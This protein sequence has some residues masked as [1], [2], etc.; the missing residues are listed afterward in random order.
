MGSQFN[1]SANPEF[2]S[3]PKT[4]WMFWAQGEQNMPT[5]VKQCVSSWRQHNP[6]WVLTIVTLDNMQNYVDMSPITERDNYSFQWLAD[7]LR[8]KLIAKS[9]GVWAD[10]TAFCAKPLDS[11]LPNY[12]EG[13]FFA[14][15]AKQ[16]DRLIQNW[17]LASIPDGDIINAWLNESEHYWVSNNF[18]P[19]N[20]WRRQ[21]YRK[22]MSFRKRGSL[23]NNIWFSPFITKTIKLQ[24]YPVVMFLF[25]KALESRPGL[26][27]LWQSK[28]KLTDEQPHKLQNDFRMNQVLSEESK[29][30][31]DKSPS[32]LHK[33][34][35]RQCPESLKQD[36][37]LNYLLT[38][39]YSAKDQ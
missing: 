2:D 13:G 21:V 39:T 1:N 20:Y 10:A 33:L 31:I 35:W 11:W 7:I 9:G 25:E 34:N 15:S 14:F 36:S 28:P 8:M 6:N 19:E 26:K 29:S 4:I 23:S 37:N 38:R 32:P 30:F 17:F 27:A 24:P 12:M 3:L 22:L 18:K 16:Q 5:I